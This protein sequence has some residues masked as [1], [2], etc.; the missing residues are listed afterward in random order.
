M[1]TFAEYLLKEKDLGAKL[2][3]VYYLSKKE[4]IYF[5]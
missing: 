3:I 5:N 2:E 4:P 1:E